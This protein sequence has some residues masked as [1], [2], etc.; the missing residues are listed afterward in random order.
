VDSYVLVQY[1]LLSE[2]SSLTL[3]VGA[4]VR[5]FVLVDSNMLSEMTL[6]PK[7]FAYNKLNL[8]VPSYHLDVNVLPHFT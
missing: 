2:A 7:S 4:S 5:L 8:A 1:C 6:L 3:D